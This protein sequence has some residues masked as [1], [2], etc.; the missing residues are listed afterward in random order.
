[1]TRL[2]LSRRNWLQETSA[3]S[4]AAALAVAA[5]LADVAVAQDA[6]A[7]AAAPRP[8]KFRFSLNTSTLRG[9]KLPLVE[10]VDIAAKV[11][12]DGIEPW[13]DEI[14]RYAKEGGSLAD[15]RKRISDQ[16]LAVASLI[17]FPE[18]IVDDDARRAKGIESAKRAM[19]LVAQIGGSM[20]AAPSA[21]AKEVEHIDLVKAGERYRALL[22]VGDQLGVI[23]QL[24]FWGH[25]KSFNHLSEAAF[26]AI[27]ARH[28]KACIL[29]DIYHLHKGGSGYEG[30]RLLDGAAL[31]VLHFNDFPE[32]PG[33]AEITDAHRVFPGD[34]VA[35]LKDVLRT[36]RNIGFDGFLSLELFNR[37]YWTRDATE[38]A[39]VGLE[40]ARL[41]SLAS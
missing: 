40:K 32:T 23:P 9:Q 12:Y 36:L 35:P 16:G 5:S 10:V 27:E 29:A 22:E 20:I 34:G 26:V 24:E 8:K 13:F 38:V 41:V 18:W 11:G 4:A 37:D 14:D 3:C 25:S 21:G 19:E 15:L 6:P 39:R 31:H 2:M 7:Q 30:L 17:A 28:P 33:R 1:M